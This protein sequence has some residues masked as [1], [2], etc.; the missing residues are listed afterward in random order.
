MSQKSYVDTRLFKLEIPEGANDDELASEDLVADNRSLVGALSWLS[1]QTRPDLT[2]AVSMAQQLQK[3]PTVGDL[4]F[5]HSTA[6]KALDF[7][8]EGLRFK[9][10]DI[11]DMVVLVY[12]DAGWANAKDTEH[13][14]PYFELTAE[15]KVASQLGDLVLFADKKC[16]AGNPSDFTVAD[17]KSRACVEGLEA[18]QH[19]RAL[20][21]T[22]LSGDLVKVEK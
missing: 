19:V 16:L 13:D 10:L 11:E 17:W 14:E 9:P 6:R 21:E 5:S 22:L 20:F 7:K 18:G 15:D 3:C 8:D 4:K 2:C 12:H 1:A